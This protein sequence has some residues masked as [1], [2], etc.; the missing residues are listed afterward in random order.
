ML[1]VK[2]SFRI[3]KRLNRQPH[4]SPVYLH[5]H[6]RGFPTA[7]SGHHCPSH[8][9][10]P[11]SNWNGHT[12]DEGGDASPAR[13]LPL[14]V[15]ASKTLTHKRRSRTNSSAA[16]TVSLRELTNH[17]FVRR[18]ELTVRSFWRKSPEHYCDYVAREVWD[19]A[20]FNQVTRFYS[21]R[22]AYPQAV[23]AFDLGESVGKDTPPCA[24]C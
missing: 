2:N 3:V 6:G 11:P 10:S 9:V 4:G 13:P 21:R 5:N 16:R 1:R 22:P 24:L 17:L 7:G 18:D 14:L 15:G 8:R 19:N 12:G 20:R 23:V